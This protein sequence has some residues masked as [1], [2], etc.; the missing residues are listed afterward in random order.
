MKKNIIFLFI[1]AV[2]TIVTWYKIYFHSFQGEGYYFFDTTLKLPC[3]ANISVKVDEEFFAFCRYDN[4][5][6][7]LY[8]VF[9]NIFFD[10]LKPYLIFLILTQIIISFCIFFLTQK[11]TN[12]KFI[13]FLAAIFF[14]VNYMTNFEMISTGNYQ[15]F[16]TRVPNFILTLISIIFYYKFLN[17]N[18]YKYY[19]FSLVIFLFSVL[20]AHV[21]MF[22][23]PFIVLLGFFHSLS[24]Y[25][26]KKEFILNI[27]LLAP[28]I[29]GTMFI[30]SNDSF[31]T[32]DGGLMTYI[33]NS[34][35]EIVKES[36]FQLTMV[37]IPYDILTLIVNFLI[38]V[39]SST[40]KASIEIIYIPVLLFYVFSILMTFKFN[41]TWGI[42]VLTSFLSILIIS[43]FNLYT[44]RVAFIYQLTSSRY[45]FPL[46]FLVSIYLAIVLY[47][48]FWKGSI[49]KRIFLIFFVVF[50][51]YSNINMSWFTNDE[52]QYKY[53]L[54]KN[55]RKYIKDLSPT[56]KKNSV[57]ILPKEIGVHEATFLKF[58]YG[59]ETMDFVSAAILTENQ[60]INFN[61]QKDIIIIYNKKKGKAMNMVDQYK[62]IV[63]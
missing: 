9:K 23:L 60:V 51:V 43:I 7:L 19:I 61:P 14:G 46:G 5:G 31:T 30:I 44:N 58:F 33:F 21:S 42:F 1:I 11:I 16:A 37:T 13:A 56:F 32:V 26:L 2:L 27:A 4:L 36:L 57:V 29:I 53:I 48:I 3:T 54:S 52:N 45:Y 49:L 39:Y 38:T 59:K 18:R 15:W 50:W 47:V 35:F 63:R 40:S 41:K 25:L 55:I 12:N 20:L 22:L 8:F 62:N 17:F 24:K 34:N 10:N 6:R 28:F